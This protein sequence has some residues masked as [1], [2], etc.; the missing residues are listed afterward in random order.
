MFLWQ[1]LTDQ[2]ALLLAK[3]TDRSGI[4]CRATMMAKALEN[5][6]LMLSQAYHIS[7][8]NILLIATF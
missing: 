8:W 2:K 5:A 3:L 4:D 1:S 7:S 6:E